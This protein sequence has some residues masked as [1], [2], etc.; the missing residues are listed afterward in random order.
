MAPC[1]SCK[2]RKTKDAFHVTQLPLG[3]TVIDF[4][5]MVEDF[6]CN[7]IVVLK[8]TEQAKVEYQYICY[9]YFAIILIHSY[10]KE[11]VLMLEMLDLIWM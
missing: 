10:I 11:V 9:Q 7:A 3:D 2:G 5:R 6:E 1:F 4:W 8:S